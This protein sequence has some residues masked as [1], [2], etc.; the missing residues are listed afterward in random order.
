MKRFIKLAV[1]CLIFTGCESNTA[2]TAPGKASINAENLF[3]AGKIIDLTHNFSKE[4][5]FWVTAKEFQLDTVSYGNTG[6]HFYSAYN[7][8][9][10]EHGGTHIDAPI[11]F[12]KGG[13]TVDEIPLEKLM[14][15][16]IKIDVSSKAKDNRDYLVSVEDFT[17]WEKENGQ[18]PDGAIILLETGY[19]NYYPDK[20][21]YLGTEERG[22][23]AV[24]KLHFPGLS[25]EAA[26]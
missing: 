2:K 12:S 16:A 15:N 8:T 9:L 24:A 23:E 5:V 18:I 13:Q 6:G 19:G 25:P 7:I 3:P 17:N 4:S 14:G 20:L 26:K 11:H 22:P 10:A 1:I 21:K